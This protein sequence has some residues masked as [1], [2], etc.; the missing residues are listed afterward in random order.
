MNPS[1]LI[2]I[3]PF[4]LLS[5]VE[6]KS[7]KT[8]T[9]TVAN[10]ITNYGVYAED[11]LTYIVTDLILRGHYPT[12]SIVN[13]RNDTLLIERVEDKEETALVI[14]YSEE[15]A[16]ADRYY[17]G[18]KNKILADFDEDGANDIIVQVH[19]EHGASTTADNWY[20]FLKRDEGY[21]FVNQFDLHGLV[22]ENISK[23]QDAWNGRFNFEK[24]EG[25]ILV[26]NSY[27]FI[28]GD[29]NCCPSIFATEKY[30]YNPQTNNFELIYQSELKK[31][32]YE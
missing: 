16:M 24:T 4:L 17:I 1:N 26:G 6:N 7:S 13:E 8:E 15:S 25:N 28:S 29:A 22:F 27:Y 2:L 3:I 9:E 30:K 10:A 21:V 14:R 31:K 12:D 32:S 20:L 5:C 18:K 11:E 23:I 19:S